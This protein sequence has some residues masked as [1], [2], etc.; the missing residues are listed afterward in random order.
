MKKHNNL[1]LVGS[2]RIWGSALAKPISTRMIIVPMIERR[3]PIILRRMVF[4]KNIL[5]DLQDNTRN[6]N[7]QQTD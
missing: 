2:D 3:I 6:I 4:M 5:N 1:K 7:E